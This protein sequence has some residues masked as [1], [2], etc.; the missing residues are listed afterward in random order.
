MKCFYTYR[1]IVAA[2]MFAVTLPC[3]AADSDS[4]RVTV[5][6]KNPKA[7]ATLREAVQTLK[8]GDTL[9]I[10]S[11]S[12][13][14]REPLF[15]AASGTE[16]API[17]I[18]GNGNEITGFDPL[19]FTADADGTQT[20]VAKVKYPFVLR[21]QGKRVLEDAAT[22]QFTGGISYD[23]NLGRLTLAP[24]TSPEGWEIS[25]RLFVVRIF[26]VSHH[27]YR[28]LSATGSLNDGFNLHGTGDK[29]LFEHIT[30]SQNL[31]EGFSSHETINSEIRQG[32]FFEND[33][34]VLNGQKTNTIL[35]QVDLHD[36]LGIGMGFGGESTVKAENVRVWGNGMTQLAMRAGVIARFKNVQVYQSAQTTRQW[37]SYMESAKDNKRRTAIIDKNFSW[38]EEKPQILDQS[39]P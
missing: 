1:M 19:V 27:T 39:A 10:A 17:V 31:D 9:W 21:H 24:G 2:G 35:S 18:E 33:N 15:I 4:H 29:L 37:L 5:D 36:N 13:P 12:G 28:N 3:F 30:G 25:T 11:G 14:Y 38:E 34:G 16:A 20:A 32:D 7:F 6:P 22:G 8:P 26:N 23:S